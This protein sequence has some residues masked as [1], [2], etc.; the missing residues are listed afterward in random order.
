MIICQTA[1]HFAGDSLPGQIERTA[2]CGF[3]G[4]S[5]LMTPLFA[6][7]PGEE[8]RVIELVE[9]YDLAVVCHNAIDDTSAPGGLGRLRRDLDD[10]AA[11]HQRTGRVRVVC[12]DPGF[13]KPDGT[14]QIADLERS[15]E[16]LLIARER[17]RPL[18]ILVGI[19]NWLINHK[20]EQSQAVARLT[21]GNV[22]CLIDLGHLNIA[23]RKGLLGG[24]TPAQFIAAMPLEVLEIHVHDN[25][26][27]A[28]HH[29][30]LGRGNVDA[31]PMVEALVARG[32][33]GFVTIEHG[34]PASDPATA[35]A[36]K[37][38]KATLEG[39]FQQAVSGGSSGG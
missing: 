39:M 31:R 22:G 15:A 11:W 33:D 24:L 34:G 35:E 14:T 9:R 3:G 8:D 4:I 12:F 25:D 30:A 16:R 38:T 5:F 26:G 1:W 23:W 20:L 13:T 29:W 17:L 32:F 36:I 18:G 27:A 37:T 7:K 6:Q 21:G 28:D 19:E 10:I 2:A